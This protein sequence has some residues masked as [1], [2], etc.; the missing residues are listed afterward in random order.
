MDPLSLTASIIAI[1]GVGGQA[2]GAVRK[3]A[4]LKNAPELILALNNEITDLHLVVSAIQDVY[5]RQR[6]WDSP[7]P[8]SMTSDIN[9]SIT[10][11]LQHA[12]NT[13]AK[14]EVLYGRLKISSAGTSTGP[15]KFNTVAWLREQRNIRQIQQDLR[16]VRIKLAGA[17]SILNSYVSWPSLSH[18]VRT[19]YVTSLSCIVPR[20]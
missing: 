8:A 16:S 20:Y 2:A 17:L 5:Q 11:S 19:Y 3:L 6:N 7:S 10:S 14:L 1:V 13:T 15:I 9:T 4:A 18:F 12:I